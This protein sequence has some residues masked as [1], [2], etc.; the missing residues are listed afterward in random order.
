MQA[1]HPFPKYVPKEARNI[2]L[3]PRLWMTTGSLKNHFY[4][5]SKPE[6][7][8]ALPLMCVL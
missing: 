5:C 8:E 6:I 1:I 2:L 4:S 7:M 3:S